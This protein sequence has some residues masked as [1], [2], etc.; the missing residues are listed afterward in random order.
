MYNRG[1]KPDAGYTDDRHRAVARPA[2][3]PAPECGTG[4]AD[5]L[6]TKKDPLN[7]MRILGRPLLARQ[8]A[9]AQLADAR[10][11]KNRRARERARGAGDHAGRA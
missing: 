8:I 10:K 1:G 11:E 2:G 6:V 7:I 3:I 5:A 4:E 9:D